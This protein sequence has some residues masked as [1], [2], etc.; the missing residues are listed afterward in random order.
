MPLTALTT[1]LAGDMCLFEKKDELL[2][3]SSQQPPAAGRGTGNPPP[4][5]FNNAPESPNSFL[6]AC[7]Y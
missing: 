4:Q 1:P 3:K 5:A 6:F 7:L 2:A